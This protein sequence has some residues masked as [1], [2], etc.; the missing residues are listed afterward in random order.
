MSDNAAKRATVY[1]EPTLHR[2][3]RRKAAHTKR[4]ISEIINEAVRVALREDDDDLA[5]F[6]DRAAEPLISYKAL[7]KRLKGS[8]RR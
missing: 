1:F 2:A 5:A 6:R 8:G 7:M 3:I 4:S